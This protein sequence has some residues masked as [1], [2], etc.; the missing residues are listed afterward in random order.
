MSAN[1]SPLRSVPVRRRLASAAFAAVTCLGF[2]VGSGTFEHVPASAIEGSPIDG[3]IGIW[4]PLLPE[5]SDAGGAS[6]SGDSI[7]TTLEL[8]G[9][10]RFE[11]FL[12]SVEG[13]VEYGVTDSV[14]MF[15]YEFLLRDTWSFAIGELSAGTGFSQMQ[16]D[17][18]WGNREISSD[19]IGAKIIGGWE[20]TFGRQPIWID[21]KIGLYDFD[22]RYDDA[23]NHET[24][25][26][27]TTTWG[28][29]VKADCDRFGIPMRFVAGVDYLRDMTTWEAG[30]I[31]TEDAVALTGAVEFRLK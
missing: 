28:V 7:G 22:G 17:R 2:I 27:F 14:E 16:W 1:S 5:L 13:G 18:D 19:Y 6:D 30:Q 8:S 24:I 25:S 3:S 23:V 21:L 26:K 9:H 11:G 15:A 20:T 29:D 12:T 31:G 4:A 10:H